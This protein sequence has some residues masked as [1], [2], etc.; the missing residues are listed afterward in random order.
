MDH[1]VR[2]RENV[3]RASD[4]LKPRGHLPLRTGDVKIWMA[5]LGGKKWR[6]LIP[7][8][9]LTY[10]LRREVRLLRE[11]AGLTPVTFLA[12][13]NDRT[14]GHTRFRVLRAGNYRMLTRRHPRIARELR[15]PSSYLDLGAIM[16][17]SAEKPAVR[18]SVGGGCE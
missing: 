6:L 8:S 13:G 2:P 15:A 3:A 1:R 4:L 18:T 16:S 5:R 17:Q 7:P 14:L 12:A 9:Y 10:I 11:A